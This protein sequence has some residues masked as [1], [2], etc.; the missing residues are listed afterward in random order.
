VPRTIARV[1]GLIAIAA[2]LAAIRLGT[3]VVALL[4][5][6]RLRR[7][8]RLL[9]GAL[10]GLSVVGLT[11]LALAVAGV[12]SGPLLLALLLAAWTAV[13]GARR[14]R[15]PRSTA[16]L[17]WIVGDAVAL[18]AGAVLLVAA[19]PAFPALLGGRDYGTYA[20]TGELIREQ[21]A[22]RVDWTPLAGVP[23]PARAGLM[24]GADP[25]PGFYLDAAGG[26]EVTPQGF[27]LMPALLAPA[28]VITDDAG[29]WVIPVIAVLGLLVAALLAARLAP[30][31]PTAAATVTAVLLLTDVAW[32]WYARMPM[33]ETLNTTLVLGGFLGWVIAHDERSPAL[34]ALG[35]ALVGAS[36]FSRPDALVVAPVLVVVLC[37]LI[38]AGRVDRQVLAFLAAAGALFLAAVAYSATF[39]RRYVSDIFSQPLH[40][41]ASL[42]PLA[43]GAAAAGVVALAVAFGIRRLGGAAIERHAG[44]LGRALVVVLAVAMLG[45]GLVAAERHF[46]G[47]RWL[48]MYLSSVAVVTGGIAWLVAVA[49]GLQRDRL[50]RAAPLLAMTGALIG[51]FAWRPTIFP[52]QFWAIRRFVAVPIPA[53]AIL[54]GC[55]VALALG[56]RGRWRVPALGGLALV[57]AFAVVHQLR[58]LRPVVGYTE[59]AGGAAALDAADRL[60]H[61]ADH[62]LAGPGEVVRNRIGIGLIAWHHEPVLGV[63]GRVGEGPSG[64]WLAAAAGDSDVRLL[65]ADGE[66]PDVDL[67]R[68]RLQPLGSAPVSIAAFDQVVDAV[69][70]HAHRI[71]PVLSAYRVVPAAGAPDPGVAATVD[72]AQAPP[73]T[74][75]GFA[76]AADGGGRTVADTASALVTRGAA[77]TLH[78]RMGAPAEPG[79]AVKVSVDGAPVGQVAVTGPARDYAFPL[80]AGQAGVADV[81]LEV[82]RPPAATPGP[83]VAVESISAA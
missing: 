73:G 55:L 6:L 41:H 81:H 43:L 66:V 18:L 7:L 2:S 9:L 24:L 62:V 80:P 56:L 61:G 75:T 51:F 63:F 35:G 36:C 74:V 64:D 3:S 15:P 46:A 79:L 40:V 1:Q 37:W 33:T 82:V 12:W 8:E 49:V 53:L 19:L 30:R 72:P 23:A 70:S 29:L 38:V 50:V 71:D 48:R 5:P 31:R 76:P 42:A 69:P 20:A 77:G 22:L 13:E 27:H 44:R 26:T 67:S 25:M 4:G 11:S 78:V 59:F 60:V 52:D 65:V 32:F 34:A 54:T 14:V 10:T 17:P 39:A 21:G 83:G 16:P 45:Y 58:D 57:L 28:G 68:V 47:V